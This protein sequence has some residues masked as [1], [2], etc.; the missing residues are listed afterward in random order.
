MDTPPP[1]AADPAAPRPAGSAWAEAAEGDFEAWR[2]PRTVAF[3]YRVGEGA[4]RVIPLADEA[5]ALA[6]VRARHPE[7]AGQKITLEPYRV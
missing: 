4:P 5:A 3:W 6:A 7:A 2:A 1:I